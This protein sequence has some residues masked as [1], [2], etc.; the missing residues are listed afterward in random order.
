MCKLHV[1]LNNFVVKFDNPKETHI[2]SKSNIEFIQIELTRVRP[3]VCFI[4]FFP[5]HKISSKTKK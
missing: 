1:N 4:H 5:S 3:N 2:I